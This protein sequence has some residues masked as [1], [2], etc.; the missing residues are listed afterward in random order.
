MILGAVSIWN[1]VLLMSHVLLS[2]DPVVWSVRVAETFILYLSPGNVV[3]WWLHVD[4]KENMAK[5]ATL[6][7]ILSSYTDDIVYLERLQKSPK[8]AILVGWKS[9]ICDFLLLVLV[10][11]WKIRLHFRTPAMSHN[12]NPLTLLILDAILKSRWY[13]YDIPCHRHLHILPN[14]V[15]LYRFRA[16]LSTLVVKSQ[17]HIGITENCGSRETVIDGYWKDISH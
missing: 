3:L 17:E 16:F 6:Y 1:P 7:V 2:F 9:N 13:A 10:H 12:H 14:F 4:S 5:L 11:V 8:F 15:I